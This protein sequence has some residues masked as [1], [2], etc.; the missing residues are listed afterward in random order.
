MPAMPPV[1]SNVLREGMKRNCGKRSGCC[2]AARPVQSATDQTIGARH[3]HND[4]ITRYTGVDLQTLFR[5]FQ[6][7]NESGGGTKITPTSPLFCSSTPQ[8]GPIVGNR[9]R[10]PVMRFISNEVRS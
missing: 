5:N 3:K 2:A 10:F 4:Q 1:T 8:F 6:F 7:T 9:V